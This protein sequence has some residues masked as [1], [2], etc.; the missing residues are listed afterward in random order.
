[1]IRLNHSIK[2]NTGEIIKPYLIENNFVFFVN[3]KNGLQGVS[4]VDDIEKR[5]IEER[6]KITVIV[7]GQDPY[8]S[9]SKK[10]FTPKEVI[11]EE[12]EEVIEEEEKEEVIEEE[13]KEEEKEKEEENPIPKPDPDPYDDLFGDM[14]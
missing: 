6:K 3:E 7:S 12:K 14:W 5:A 13:E 10:D 9:N 4:P 1:M 11:E 2:L 8:I